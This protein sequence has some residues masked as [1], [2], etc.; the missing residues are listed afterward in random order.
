MSVNDMRSFFEDF[1]K[2]EG[3]GQLVFPYF[4]GLL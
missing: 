3:T 1:E 4:M 2:I